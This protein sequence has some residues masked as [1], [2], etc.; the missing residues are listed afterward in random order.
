MIMHDLQNSN[1]EFSDEPRALRDHA[2]TFTFVGS[3]RRS[4]EGHSQGLGL[5]IELGPGA[6]SL[7]RH[8]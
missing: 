5:L 1:C 8:R 4:G 3:V 6:V 2:F 7:H